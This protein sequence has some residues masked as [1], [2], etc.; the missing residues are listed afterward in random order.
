MEN[1]SSAN[2][3]N[4]LALIKLA[5]DDSFLC[6]DLCQGHIQ[7]IDQMKSIHIYCCLIRG[8]N[9]LGVMFLVKLNEREKNKY[10]II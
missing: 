5:L 2:S 4:P 10:T 6:C 3:G 8:F 9:M 1:S 7:M